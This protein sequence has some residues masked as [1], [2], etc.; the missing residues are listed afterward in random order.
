MLD[1]PA[2]SHDSW[3][4]L[5]ACFCGRFLDRHELSLGPDREIGQ[6]RHYS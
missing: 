4:R 1:D 2:M 6:Q 5:T 3:P